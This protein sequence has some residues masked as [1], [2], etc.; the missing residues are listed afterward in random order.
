MRRAAFAVTVLV[1]AAAVAGC[2]A[3]DGPA[4]GPVDGPGAGSRTHLQVDAFPVALD[5]DHT[6][7]GL[8]AASAGIGRIWHVATTDAGPVPAQGVYN[9]AV[10]TEL[11]VASLASVTG[12]GALAP[13]LTLLLV[14]V[15]EP[16]HPRA[17][18]RHPVPGGGV[19]AVAITPDDQFAFLGA[20]F[21]GAVGIWTLDVSNPASP[22]HAG[23]TPLP[24]EGPH[25]VRYAKVGDQELLL[26]SI[27]H[28]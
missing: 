28:V 5:H 20:E 14:D 6:D 21:S 23:F 17:L 24:T 11:L 8:H 26:A 18:S 3:D 12:G 25:N 9:L 10:G 2:L 22:T 15:S 4:A 19:E 27:S 7:P 16:E 1:L 13:G